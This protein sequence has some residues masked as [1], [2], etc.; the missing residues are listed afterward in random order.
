MNRRTNPLSLQDTSLSLRPTISPVS[1][2]LTSP[3]LVGEHWAKLLSQ[4]WA[5]IH[6][7]LLFLMILDFVTLTVG[8]LFSTSASTACPDFTYGSLF[9]CFSLPYCCCC[10]AN[11]KLRQTWVSHGSLLPGNRCHRPWCCLS[12]STSLSLSLSPQQYRDNFFFSKIKVLDYS[13]Y[14]QI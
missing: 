2:I 12:L 3:T 5:V 4:L 14:S 8:A 7:F 6:K 11:I 9:V 10:V 1:A 13:L